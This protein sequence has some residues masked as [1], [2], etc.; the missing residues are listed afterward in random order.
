M[1]NNTNDH[2]R[3][4]TF[5]CLAK[6]GNLYNFYLH[7]SRYLCTRSTLNEVR[8]IKSVAIIFIMATSFGLLSNDVY[9]ISGNQV[10]PRNQ[11]VNGH[12]QSASGESI[13]GVS[14]QIKGTKIGVITNPQGDYSFNVRS[15]NDVLIYSFIGYVDQEIL[16]GGRKTIN[17]TLQAKSKNLDEVVVTALGIKREERSLGYAVSSVKM[18]SVTQANEP[19][20]INS[21]SGKVPGMVIT[22]SAGGPGGSSRVLIR[23]NTSISGDNQPLYVIDGVPIENTNQGNIGGGKFASG[24]D[25]GDVMSSLN[26]ADIESISVLKG[27]SASALYGSQASNGVIMITMKKGTKKQASVELNSTA[28][29][30]VQ[31]TKFNDLQKI[32]GQGQNGLLPQDQI[33]SQASIFTNWGPR[34]NPKL[35]VIGFDGV[36]RPY[37]LADQSLDA[38]LRKGQSFTNSVSVSQAVGK[39]SFR[40]A[41]TNL[42]TKDIVPKTGL[43]RHTF[44]LGNTIAINDNLSVSTR[45]MYMYEKVNNRLALGDSYNNIAK[46]FFGLAN[47]IDPRIF[48]E[49][50]KTSNGD[51][52]EWG[53]GIYNYNPYWVIND[54]S[55]T[56]D[57]NRIL[58]GVTLNYKFAKYFGLQ[59][60]G[61]ADQ[62]SLTFNEYSPPT[63]PS[64][65]TG[66]LVQNESKIMTL[67]GDA[68]L[69]FEKDLSPTI[70][71]TARGG[72]NYYD[73]KNQGFNNIYSLMTVPN[74]ISPNSFTD[75][76]IDNYFLRKVKNSVYGILAMSYKRII[77]VD[78][79]FRRD[80]SSTLPVNNNTYAYPSVS[81]S[82][83]FS[84]A[85]K[86]LPSFIS[87]GKLRASAAEVGNDAQP[88]GLGLT[89][90]LYP[91]TFNGQPSGR[92]SGSTIPNSNLKPT[93]TRSF[94]TGLAMRF[95]NNRIGFDFTYYRSRSRDQIN[96]VPA[97]QSSGYSNQIVN[98][99]TI[100]NRGFEI[101]LDANI[102]TTTALRWNVQINAARN[103]NNVESLAEGIPFLTLASARWLGVS[104]VAMKGQPYG[105]ILGYDFQ[106]DPNGNIILDPATRR[107][108]QSIQ[109]Q[110]LGNG[111][112]NWTGGISNTFS[113]N[114]FSLALSIDIKQGA[115][116][117]SM[118]NLYTVAR[119]DDKST[120][121]GREE[122]NQSEADRIA[123]GMSSTQWFTA[124]N[125]KG[126]VPKGVIK[127]TAT[128]GDISYVPNQQT[129]S[130]S[131][132]WGGYVIDGQGVASPFIYD[133]SYI[134]IRDIS[135]S[136][137]LGQS[138]TKSI[139]LGDV[140]VGFVA[141]NPLILK[142]SVP[143]IDPDSNTYNGNGQG[144]ELGSLPVRRGY[145]I[146]LNVKF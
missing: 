86:N 96:T 78:A 143:N 7:I 24:Y 145:G 85:F 70:N 40:L 35:N 140:S 17:V 20:L 114:H 57:K 53:G 8:L 77:Y 68:M 135:L 65:V 82:F 59:L 113:Y 80:A 34:L 23:G 133:A 116:I 9:A 117:F 33:E 38:F 89:Y 130:P 132:Y 146:N 41:Y 27:P 5:P 121:E 93:R 49:N 124:G 14:V 83:I 3:K 21:L 99:G 1:T 11:E 29:I 76:A 97:P 36:E 43:D 55:N 127:T 64:A 105:A 19:N 87:F 37:T 18:D 123:A 110:V 79:T 73:F 71:L 104:V 74:L 54:M 90:E 58:G 46:S 48:G 119:G 122:W 126:F 66:S 52:V 51:Y 134:K 15:N 108:L 94:E 84:D 120:L 22:Q 100:S 60:Q 102:I 111:T 28:T 95:L 62:N 2:C 32:Y 6:N 67:Q 139:G 107:P 101:A 31:A 61:S 26:P 12:I 136:Y 128:N 106:R 45:L 50:Y 13:A 10:S 92:I 25:M 118:T 129:I 131:S 115:N 72:V 47:N 56:T 39:T 142:K 109:P 125:Q 30:D 138:F 141:R 137:K 63:T 44:N 144:L 88:Y 103:I 16:V 98:V 42:T 75:K 112:F 4:K 69:S 81:G 91:F